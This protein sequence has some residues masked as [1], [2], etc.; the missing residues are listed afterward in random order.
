M[1]LLT[2]NSTIWCPF[3]TAESEYVKT[4]RDNGFDVIHTHIADGGDFFSVEPPK[5]DYIISNPPYS[6]KGAIFKR[7]FEIGIP[8]AMLINIQGLFDNRERFDLFRNKR[9]ELLYLNP[10]VD[11]QKPFEPS[12]KAGVPF[13]SVYVCSGILDKE[14]NFAYIDKSERWAN[15]LAG[16]NIE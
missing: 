7:L 5:C 10:R 15:K 2:P 14:I 9:I 16:I 4:F 1:K 13:Q 12:A 3:D 6:V 8:F 11:Y